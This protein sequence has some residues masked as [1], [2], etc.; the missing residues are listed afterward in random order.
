ML[1]HV[2]IRRRTYD[3]WKLQYT[4][5]KL[6]IMFLEMYLVSADLY[7]I[8]WSIKINFQRKR[9][10]FIS[11]THITYMYYV[12]MPYVLFS[13]FNT[14]RIYVYIFKC[15]MSHDITAFSSEK[16]RTHNAILLVGDYEDQ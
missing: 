2:K 10:H 12:G 7:I 4:R 6:W 13:L 9:K 8:Y 5:N 15:A 3:F 11:F 14:Q 1:D 16:W